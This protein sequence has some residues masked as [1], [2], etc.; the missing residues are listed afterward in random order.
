MGGLVWVTGAAKIGVSIGS[1]EDTS[2]ISPFGLE[3]YFGHYPA[4]T[5]FKNMMHFKQITLA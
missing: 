3:T 4:G 5:S 1:D 2:K